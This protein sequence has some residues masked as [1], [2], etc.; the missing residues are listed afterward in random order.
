MINLKDGYFVDRDAL[1][2]KKEGEERKEEKK[3][4]KK[5]NLRG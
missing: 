1:V 2:E 5:E 4:G 3:E